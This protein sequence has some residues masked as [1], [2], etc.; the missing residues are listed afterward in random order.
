MINRIAYVY[1][2]LILAAVLAVSYATLTGA[3]PTSAAPDSAHGI[4]V[5]Q[6][7]TA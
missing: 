2:G 7:L 5:R 1:S 4:L 3:G 6:P